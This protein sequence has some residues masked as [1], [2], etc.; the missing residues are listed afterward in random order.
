MHH[1][2]GL[3]LSRIQFTVSDN[4]KKI[5]KYNILLL[6]VLLSCNSQ[7]DGSKNQN[8]LLEFEFAV[9]NDEPIFEDEHLFDKISKKA[10][11]EKIGKHEIYHIDWNN[12]NEFGEIGIDYLG[13][14]SELEKKPIITKLKTETDIRINGISYKYII[15]KTDKKIS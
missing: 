11:M 12:N 13:L 4:I 2:I 14:K 6:T 5:M 7:N 3:H 1:D 9:L 15:E 10:K 8:Q